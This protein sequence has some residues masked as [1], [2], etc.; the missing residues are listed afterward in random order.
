MASAKLGTKA[1]GSIIKLNESGIPVE[2]IIVQQGKPASGNYDDSCNGTW[3]RRK[4][5]YSNRQWH[6]SNVN[7]YANSAI[8]SWL[9]NESSGFLSL[10]DADIRAAVKTVKIPYRPGSGTS[11]TVSSGA[12]GLSCKAFLLSMKEVDL[13]PRYSPTE[14]AALEYFSGGGNSQRV[15][16]LNGS[17][18]RW[19]SRSP[20]C[21]SDNDTAYCVKLD[22]AASSWLC[23]NSYGCCPALI[24][25]SEL[26]VSDDGTVSTNEPPTAPG[27]IDVTAPVAGQP[28]TV[29]LTAATDPDG[30]VAAYVIQR[31]VDGGGWQQVYSGPALTFTD[32]VGANWQSVQ[33]RAA[34]VD[35]EGAQGPS[36]ESEVLP[37]RTGAVIL[38][39]PASGQGEHAQPF[40]LGPITLGLTPAAA[41]A[42]IA[43]AVLLDGAETV[44]ASQAAGDEITLHIDPR[45]MARGA[46]T[47]TVTASKEAYTTA[48]A[49][50][51][52]TVPAWDGSDIAKGRSGRL[53]DWLGRKLLPKT[54]AQDCLGPGGQDMATWIAELSQGGGSAAAPL[55]PVVRA[56]PPSGRYALSPGVLYDF[57]QADARAL[58]FTFTAPEAGKAAAYHVMFKSGSVRTTLTLPESVIKPEDF[59]VE[60]N[61]IYE[62][63]ICENLMLVQSWGVA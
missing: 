52:Y 40:D 10:L 25:D 12:N 56:A 38:T 49:Q 27:S 59:A 26:L 43:F 22:G 54:L 47:L 42:G 50:Y 37:V 60:A 15:A 14:G 48:M 17:P 63:S 34:A 20:Y 21:Y 33:Y 57:T 46:H 23:S 3:V 55:E 9:N 7:D 36:I 6:T 44:T 32:T 24:L 62:V 31:R 61:K 45:V 51:T 35:N 53:E 13:T 5:I 28:L 1:S 39:G 11:Y 19:W 8:D 29:T 30:I 18:A 58:T 41:D 16:N 4:D 2:Y